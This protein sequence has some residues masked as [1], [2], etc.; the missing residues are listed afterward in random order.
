MVEVIRLFKDISLSMA[1]DFKLTFVLLLLFA[2]YCSGAYNTS[3]FQS[4]IS[5]IPSS[6]WVCYFEFEQHGCTYFNRQI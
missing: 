5:Y 2:M 1:L 3:C 4:L 6:L